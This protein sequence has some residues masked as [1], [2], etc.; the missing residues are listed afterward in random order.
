MYG[1]IELVGLS[2]EWRA[3]FTHQQAKLEK[4]F[5]FPSFF[6]AGVDG[7]GISKNAEVCLIMYHLLVLSFVGA[8]RSLNVLGR[9]AWAIMVQ[10]VVTARNDK[11]VL[12]YV[13]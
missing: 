7:R 9:Q 8:I 4:L 12:G 2:L 3:Y 6:G 5:C 1:P 10:N 13:W 11:T